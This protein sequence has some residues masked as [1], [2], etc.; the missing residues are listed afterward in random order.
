MWRLWQRST[1]AYKSTLERVEEEARVTASNNAQQALTEMKERLVDL[2]VEH[3]YFVEQ[4]QESLGQYQTQDREF[5]QVFGL[6]LSTWAMDPDRHSREL[7]P[8]QAEASRE[9]SDYLHH[10]IRPGGPRRV[11]ASP[12]IE[13]LSESMS[14]LGQS[15]DKPVTPGRGLTFP[16]PMHMDQSGAYGRGMPGIS[17]L[18]PIVSRLPTPPEKAPVEKLKLSDSESEEDEPNHRQADPVVSVPPLETEM[19][20]EEALLGSGPSSPAGSGGV[21]D[22]DLLEEDDTAPLDGDDTHRSDEG[23]R[24]CSTD[25]VVIV[26]DEEL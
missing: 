22:D 15:E 20:E 17:P 26:D 25:P 12:R 6:R 14:L 13:S 3:N 23:S 19:T 8:R 18:P 9:A 1:Q 10:G 21:D 5:Y 4:L 16:L 11:E 2:Q 7:R 24:P